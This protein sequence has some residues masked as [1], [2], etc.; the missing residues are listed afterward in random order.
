MGDNTGG[1]EQA[2]T[3]DKKRK[4]RKKKNREQDQKRLE[5]GPCRYPPETGTRQ[6]WEPGPYPTRRVMPI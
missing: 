6:I 2:D 5:V 1:V 3:K 4:K